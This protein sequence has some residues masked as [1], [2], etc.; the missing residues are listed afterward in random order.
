MG[1]CPSDGFVR[2]LRPKTVLVWLKGTN[3]ERRS[4][5]TAWFD[6]PACATQC[7]HQLTAPRQPQCGHIGEPASDEHLV[8]QSAATDAAHLL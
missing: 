2:R 1:P 8:K 7:T 4:G 3:A 6:S 5:A